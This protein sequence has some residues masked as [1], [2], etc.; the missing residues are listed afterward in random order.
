MLLEW[1]GTALGNWRWAEEV[2]FAGLHSAN[3]PSGAGIL[4][5][6]LDLIVVA[7]AGIPAIRP[8][9]EAELVW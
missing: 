6:L 1:T 2:P 8:R 5:I 3:P 9:R 7:I 4:Y